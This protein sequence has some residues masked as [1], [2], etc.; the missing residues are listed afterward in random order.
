[1]DHDHVF[2]MFSTG[3]HTASLGH[4]SGTSNEALHHI[5][6]MRNHHNGEKITDFAAN[7][8]IDDNKNVEKYK[9]NLPWRRGNI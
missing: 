2:P 6:A 9:I 7:I 4:S 8:R 1:M 5:E 3:F